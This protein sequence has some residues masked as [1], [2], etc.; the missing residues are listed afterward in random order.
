MPYAVSATVQKKRGVPAMAQQ[1]T[2]P[3][4]TQEYAGSTPGLA[5]WVGNLVLL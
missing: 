2:N 1:L 4:V 5:Q 3:T